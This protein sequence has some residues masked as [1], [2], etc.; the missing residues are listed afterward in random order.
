MRRAVYDDIRF[1]LDRGVDGFRIDAM[2]LMSKHPDL[3]DAKIEFP[4]EKYQNGAEW[5]ASGPKMHEYLQEMR[6]E[7]FDH[8]DI[9]TVGEL[10][11]NEDNE[12]VRKYVAKDRRELN[13]V[14]HGMDMDFGPGGK[15]TRDDF[16][17]RKMRAVTERWQTAMPKFDGWNTIYLDN[18]DN[19]RSVSR[20]ASDAPRHR[21]NAAKMLAT[22]I[23]TLSGTPFL[24]EGQEIGTANLGKDKDIAAYIDFEGRNWYE[25][26][27]EERGG[28]AGRMED[29]MRELQLKAR[30]H[31]RLP[32]QW[33]DS[34]NAGFCAEGVK[35]WMR[36]NSDY[37]EWNVARQVKDPASVLSYWRV[38]L[39]LRKQYPNV[40]V[41]G[42]YEMLPLEE[43][44]DMVVGY[45]RISHVSQQRVLVL[46]NF[47][48]EE[49]FVTAGKFAKWEVFVSNMYHG[50]RVK[51][52]KINLQAYE[53]VVLKSW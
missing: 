5:Y 45:E 4:G 16:H 30:D 17:P 8:Y 44:G 51:D 35:P 24:L 25:K 12:S 9:L 28:D 39:S 52:G 33:D 37:R 15:Y 21:A 34:P 47:A 6:R 27:L 46:L 18:H 38:M 1:W 3:P 7:V 11:S 41:Y 40:F 50:N 19:G 20:Y 29:V 26:V 2:N 43:T 32:M 23:C 31:G 42:G 14:F 53:A 48:E 13:M 10:G 22:Y 49:V 36:V